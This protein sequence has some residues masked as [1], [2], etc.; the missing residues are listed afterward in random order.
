VVVTGHNHQYERFAPMTPTGTLNTTNG[1]RQ[2]VAG[3]GG[4]SHYS[5]GTIQPNS[6][7]RNSTAYGVLKLTLHSNSYD[8]EFVPVAGQTYTDNG[9]TACH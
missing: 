3:M 8:R 6:E 4:A 1:I 9:T 2:F 7:A 5:F